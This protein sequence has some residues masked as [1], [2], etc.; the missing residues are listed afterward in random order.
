MS[1]FDA[2]V[3]GAGFSGM[4]CAI[5]LG[6][7]GKKVALV[8]QHRV[9]G[10]LNSYFK[11][12]VQ[13]ELTIFDSGLH[14]LTNYAG[15]NNRQF[16]LGKILR[17]LR[18]KE[19][20]LQLQ[21]QIESFITFPWGTFKFTNDVEVFWDQLLTAFPSSAKALESFQNFLQTYDEFAPENQSATFE[22][23]RE[24]LKQFFSDTRLCEALIAGPLCYGSSHPNTM[25]WNLFICLFRS[26]FIEGICRPAQGILG[27][28]EPLK[29]KLEAWNVSLLMD[30]QVESIQG[31]E[32]VFLGG[33]RLSGKQIFSSIGLF[34][35]NQ[36]MQER[37]VP[38]DAGAR[39]T[40]CEVGWAFKTKDLKEHVPW[41]LHFESLTENIQYEI[42]STPI[43]PNL[44]IW[45]NSANYQE[46]VDGV[47]FL[48]L[49]FLAN[50]Q[51][52]LGLNQA[53]YKAAKAT[54][55]VEAN[56]QLAQRFPALV[57]LVQAYD[58]FTPKTIHRYTLHNQ[59]AIYGGPQK[60]KTGQTP[61]ENIFVI[62][63]DQGLPGIVGAM[64]SGITMANLHGMNL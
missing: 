39:I 29:Q 18:L 2:V 56:L 13:G 30:K 54:F 4:S 48:K 6:M 53:E 8:E 14:A 51:Y 45:S 44:L 7:M 33:G 47:S 19:A 58:A 22:C 32:I 60:W 20:E 26:L 31:N 50:G 49:S 43:Q 40:L 64:L 12:K 38:M 28:I 36:L 35:L 16:P 9:L 27:L 25:D 23:T 37:A 46:S 11:R 52:W 21:P 10:G 61:W 3:L 55:I 34:E 5:R 59:G 57:P 17:Q 41:A 42:P 62:G 24:K 63:A 15:I 1:D